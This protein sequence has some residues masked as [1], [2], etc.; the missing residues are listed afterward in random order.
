MMYV[1]KNK[2]YYIGMS[3]QGFILGSP[4]ENRTCSIFSPQVP[5]RKS[6]QG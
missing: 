3:K 1:M 5:I 4:W 6:D 2:L